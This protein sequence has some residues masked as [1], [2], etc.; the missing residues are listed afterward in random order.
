MLHMTHAVRLDELVSIHCFNS[1]KSV[2][3]ML[4]I[5]ITS[6]LFVD[7][8]LQLLPQTDFFFNVA[9]IVESFFCIGWFLDLSQMGDSCVM[10]LSLLMGDWTF[11]IIV[12]R[13]VEKSNHQKL[14]NISWTSKLFEI[15]GCYRA[16]VEKS[17]NVH[18]M[19]YGL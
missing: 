2:T 16:G 7:K 12:W 9:T 13:S 18:K 3:W 10:S 1:Y 6:S 8:F 14:W 15:R 4:S 5:P 19:H 17:F 11:F